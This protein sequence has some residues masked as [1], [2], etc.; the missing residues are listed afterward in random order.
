MMPCLLLLILAAD[1]LLL[2]NFEEGTNGWI[3][4]GK[5]ASIRIIHDGT[6]NGTGALAFDYSGGEGTNLAALPLGSTS[7]ARM[8]TIRFWLK[9]D[10]PT[11]VAVVLSEKKPGGDYTALCWS[12]GNT[13]QKVELAANDFRLNTGKNDAVDPDGK[14]DLDA[15]QNIGILDVRS[16]FGVNA[17]TNSP[18]MM[19]SHAGKH[20]LF[21]DDFE[22]G[23]GNGVKQVDKSILDNFSTPQLQWFT[24]GGMELKPEASGLRAIYT[25]SLDK[26]VAMIR[27]VGHADLKGKESLAFEISSQQPADLLFSLE[28]LASGQAQGPRY[29][30]TLEVPGGGKVVH[31]EV[32]IEA[33]EHAADSPNDPN[34]KLDLDKIKTLT[35]LDITGTVSQLT[36]KNSLWIGNIRGVGNAP[37]Q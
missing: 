10:I 28:E 13:W 1:P 29:N 20:T 17:D 35:I 4:V 19:D 9:T 18:I 25:Q 33:F 32:V 3:V 12:T 5:T 6:H 27:M 8:D 34:G 31:R 30:L 26:P 15:V 36:G 21:L 22:I 7:I 23:T 37:P 2:H 24:L 16:V 11:A 14:L